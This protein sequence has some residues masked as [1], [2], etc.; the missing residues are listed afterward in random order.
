[1]INRDDF[2]IVIFPFLDEDIPR[3]A[4]CGVYISRLIRF[5]RVSSHVADFKLEIKF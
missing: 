1:M 4:S 3:A 5:A 2:D